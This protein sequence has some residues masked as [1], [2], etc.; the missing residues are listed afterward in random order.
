ML[1]DP[2]VSSPV[3]SQPSPVNQTG[4]IGA[5]AV[6]ATTSWE[7][8][9]PKRLCSASSLLTYQMI[10]HSLYQRSQLMD[11]DPKAGDTVVFVYVDLEIKNWPLTLQ[12]NPAESFQYLTN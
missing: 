2:V 8:F 1:A 10:S 11:H 6:T 9:Y 3:W 5:T 4:R 7:E 12:D